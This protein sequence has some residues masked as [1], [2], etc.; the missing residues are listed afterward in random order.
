M[1]KIKKIECLE[2]YKIKLTFNDKTQ[3]IVDLKKYKNADKNSVFYPFRDLNF[4]RSVKLD[5]NLE[6]LVWPNGV[7]LCPDALYELG[8][9][10]QEIKR[11][12]VMCHPAYAL[13][14]RSK[15]NNA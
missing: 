15:K 3:K 9:E 2:G 11:S 10:V 5:K 4:F 14:K 8:K 7:D 6:T 13:S 1:H 12:R